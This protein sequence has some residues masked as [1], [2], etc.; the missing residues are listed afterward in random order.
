MRRRS[1]LIYEASNYRGLVMMR[2][3]KKPT[4]V[5]Q[6]HSLGPFPVAAHPFLSMCLIS[7]KKELHF[8]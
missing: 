7:V 6:Q 8:Q 2:I 4:L 1:G 5:L 3:D